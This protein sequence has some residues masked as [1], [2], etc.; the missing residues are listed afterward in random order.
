[1]SSSSSATSSNPPSESVVGGGGGGGASVGG[2]CLISG[3]TP[4]TLLGDRRMATGLLPVGRS[5]RG[6]SDGLGGRNGI[7]ELG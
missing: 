2:L 4:E 3:F 7:G 1:M 5:G 6:D